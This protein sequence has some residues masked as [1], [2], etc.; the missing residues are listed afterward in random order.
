MHIRQA[1]ARSIG[2]ILWVVLSSCGPTNDEPSP[3]GGASR[4]P[5]ASADAD[6][7]RITDSD[8]G[9]AAAF[10]SDR[11]GRPDYLDDDS[12][13]YGLGDDVEAGDDRVETGPFDSD[14]DG[15][16]DFRDRDSD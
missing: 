16:D 12:D 15:T 7:D 6:G 11:D 3:D 4:P 13:G 9:R 5:P 10:D 14:G 2:T 8:E 1:W